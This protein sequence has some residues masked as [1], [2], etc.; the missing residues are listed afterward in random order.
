MIDRVIEV[1]GK[2]ELTAIKNVTINEPFFQGIFL[3][4]LLCLEFYSWKL[5]HRLPCFN[6]EARRRRRQACVFMSADKV[7]F[8]R[9]VK[10]ETRSKL[11]SKY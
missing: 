8:R 10:L 6:V 2:D 5:W 11:T 3:E 7:K 4:I 9:A 1:R